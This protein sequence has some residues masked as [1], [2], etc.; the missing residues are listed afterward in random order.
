MGISGMLSCIEEKLLSFYTHVQSS[1]LLK[2]QAH[3]TK[4]FFQ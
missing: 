1:G 3:H 4:T 2:E